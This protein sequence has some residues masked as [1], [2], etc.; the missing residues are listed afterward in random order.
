MQHVPF[1]IFSDADWIPLDRCVTFQHSSESIPCTL[2]HICPNHLFSGNH[3]CN[4]SNVPF[5]DWF[6]QTAIFK[7]SCENNSQN[8]LLSFNE[9][10]LMCCDAAWQDRFQMRE[11]LCNLSSNVMTYNQTNRA[12]VKPS[13]TLALM[14][15]LGLL[16]II[17]NM[18]VLVNSSRVLKQSCQSFSNVQKIHHIMLIN[19]ALA[20]LLM[21]VNLVGRCVLLSIASVGDGTRKDEPQHL[22]NIL[23]VIIFVSSQMSVTVLVLITS[24]RFYSTFKPLKNLNLNVAYVLIALG[25]IL[26]IFIGSVPL[27]NVERMRQVFGFF[28]DT[29]CKGTPYRFTYTLM[30]DYIQQFIKSFNSACSFASKSPLQLRGGLKTQHLLKILQ[31]L[32]LVSKSPS[33]YNYYQ[34]I[35]VCAPSLYLSSVDDRSFFGLSLLAFNFT[36]FFYLLVAYLSICYKSTKRKSFMF[37]CCCCC[38]GLR[39]D[40]DHSARDIEDRR[41]QCRV[42]FIIVTD[43]LCWIPAA[44]MGFWYTAFADDPKLRQSCQFMMSVIPSLGKV[45]GI[46]IP[47]NS[48]VNPLVYTSTMNSVINV[49]FKLCGIKQIKTEDQNHSDETPNT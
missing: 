21:G 33:F 28:K 37:C 10:G 34:E 30:R 41:L 13:K 42:F 8:S 44:I 39:K 7:A 18:I 45:T 36:A 24:F 27:L 43:L 46:L 3:V 11:T 4:K 35:S 31:H 17:G 2:F 47:I 25:W 6:N 22:C 15:L 14:W 12:L 16:A 49:V 5:D 19:L 48:V 40:G 29:G 38:S 9:T 26:W 20:D 1:L 23:G 32:K